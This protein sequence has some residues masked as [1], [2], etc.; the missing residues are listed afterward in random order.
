M[1]DSEKFNLSD[2]AFGKSPYKVVHEM[3]GMDGPNVWMVLDDCED[4]MGEFGNRDG[5]EKRAQLFKEAL[6]K[7][8]S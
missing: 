6:E 2:A 3:R 1:R 4:F 5:A 8:P 7:H